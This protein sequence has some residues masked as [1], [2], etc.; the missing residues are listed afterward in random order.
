MLLIMSAIW[1]LTALLLIILH[2]QHRQL[3]TR[4]VA[5]DMRLFFAHQDQQ[6][7]VHCVSASWLSV[8]LIHGQQ[9]RQTC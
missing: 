9:A 4:E 6:S 7:G 1:V 2:A 5:C 8:R 3:F